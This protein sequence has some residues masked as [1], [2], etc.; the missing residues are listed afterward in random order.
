[1]GRSKGRLLACIRRYSVR[2]RNRG[3]KCN[4][5]KK[6]II[7]TS[8]TNIKRWKCLLYTSRLMQTKAEMT[9]MMSCKH[10]IRLALLRHW[11]RQNGVEVKFEKDMNTILFWR[12]LSIEFIERVV[13]ENLSNIKALL[14]SMCL[15]LLHKILTIYSDVA[16]NEQVHL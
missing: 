4:N 5:L 15:Y 16:I 12:S 8:Y 10:N 6:S 13:S 3:Q 1:M 9:K 7:N 2:S 14:G 11:E